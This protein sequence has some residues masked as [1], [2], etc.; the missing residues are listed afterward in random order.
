MD[1]RT[2]LKT[3]ESKTFKELKPGEQLLQFNQI[4]VENPKN[5]DT[6]DDFQQTPLIYAVRN[7][8]YECAKAL[9]KAGVN[10]NAQDCSGNTALGLATVFQ[11]DEGVRL[12]LA[13]GAE[14]N[15]DYPPDGG[16]WS[17]YNCLKSSTGEPLQTKL[18][19]ENLLLLNEKKELMREKIGIKRNAVAMNQS[20][21]DD[22]T[23]K[24]IN[25]RIQKLDLIINPPPP[26]EEKTKSGAKCL[27][28]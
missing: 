11:W 6:S 7:K 14:I 22:E 4:L 8:L 27:V 12:L 10:L 13:R 25:M 19:L 20:T 23:I 24:M 18:A 1:T 3:M 21:L 2:I 5:I 26:S 15:L 9:I 16:I 17:L 28:M